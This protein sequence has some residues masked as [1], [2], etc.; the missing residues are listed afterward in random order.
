M[1]TKLS[2]IQRKEQR[3]GYLFIM[4]A[5]LHLLL[6]AV[7]PIFFALYL[8]FLDWD[9]LGETI[10]EA[11][12]A[13]LQNYANQFEDTGFWNAM[14]NSTRYAAASVILSV[15]VGLGVAVMV[16]QKLRGVQIFRTL[17]YI[18]A[19]SSG[20]AISMLWI[21]VYLPETGLINTMLGAMGFDNTTAFL[22][23]VGLAMWALV[24][25]SIWTGL[26][27]KMIIFLAGIMGVPPALYEAA[28]MDGAT[29]WTQFRHVT[30]PLLAPTTFFVMVTSTITAFQVFTEIYMMTQG[31]PMNTTDVVGYHIY[32]TAWVK[33][34]MGGAAAQSFI[35][36]VVIAAI[37]YFQYRFMRN[38]L[39]GYSVD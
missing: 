29:K 12:F 6:F 36:L 15:I 37:A 28:E 17:Y 35:L 38:Q 14:W 4:P 10:F 13:G 32:T 27:P 31:G 18:P 7:I 25:M 33:F 1:A 9:I 3:T 20:V 5:L 2:G 22:D 16:A 8:S 19:I 21:Y 23:E 34:D 30:L 26:G 24:F 11:G 39:E